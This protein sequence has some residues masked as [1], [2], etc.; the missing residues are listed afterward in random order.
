V[1]LTQVGQA[2]RKHL[3]IEIALLQRLDQGKWSERRLLL[4][5]QEIILMKS[6]YWHAWNNM[7]ALCNLIN[8]LWMTS[9]AASLEMTH[10]RSLNI[11][12]F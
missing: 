5:R 3:D 7:Q 2:L 9:A 1:R 12:K 4:Q 11:T 6:G 8:A 10:I